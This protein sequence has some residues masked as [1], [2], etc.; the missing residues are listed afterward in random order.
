VTETNDKLTQRSLLGGTQTYEIRDDLL[1]VT[2]SA[3]LKGEKVLDFVL[4]SLNPEPVRNGDR[5]EFYG[6]V[7]C[8]PMVSLRVDKPDR[9]S[10]EAFVERLGA[11]IREEYGA[12]TGGKAP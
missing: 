10:F 1:R 2:S 5:L 4:A 3:P 6:R 12:F 9:A 11:K 7:K 8:G